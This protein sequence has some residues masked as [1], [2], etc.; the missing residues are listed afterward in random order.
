M[1]SFAEANRSSNVFVIVSVRVLTPLM[2]ATPMATARNVRVY[3]AAC[4]R[5]SRTE[6]LSTAGGLRT[7]T[8]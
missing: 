5:R 2:K 6:S 8:F 3:R 4:A 1:P 7:L